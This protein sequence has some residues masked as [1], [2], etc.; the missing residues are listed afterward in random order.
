MNPVDVSLDDLAQRCAE[1]TSKYVRQI[2]NDSRYC[3]ELFRR[4]LVERIPDA[5]ARIYE[6]YQPLLL[7][8]VRRHKQF[9][10]TDE[11]AE[12]FGT[13]AF[14]N[15]YF[16]IGGARFSHFDNLAKVLA[17]LKSCVFTAV[18]QYARDKKP[19]D[20]LPP[21]IDVP[22]RYNPTAG[23]EADE[24]W[25]YICSLLPD[26]H[27]RLLARC[28]FILDMKPREIVSQYPDIW[29]EERKVTVAMQRIRRTLHRDRR[30]R[31]WFEADSD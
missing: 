16:A 20:L 22:V 27:D 2:E 21:D 15:F 13:L 25:Q 17:Y 1:E 19:G 10:L 12:Y 28:V 30:L 23:V 3:F 7:G 4:A 18:A 26:A 24:L 14:R 6:I 31:S 8:W 5:L 29:L 9:P 11:T